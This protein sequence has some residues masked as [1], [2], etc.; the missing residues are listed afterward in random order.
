MKIDE[1]Y[2]QF[3]KIDANIKNTILLPLTDKN[4]GTCFAG[5]EQGEI[6]LL[7]AAVGLANCAREK[8]KKTTDIR[9]YA[10]LSEDHKILIRAIA[11]SASKHD[12]SILFRGTEVLKIVEEYANGGLKILHEKIH[13][14]GFDMSIEEEISKMLKEIE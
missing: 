2:P 1:N 4:T 8:S 14:N 12:Y 6:Y 13:S 11:L 7:G 9:L 3:I 10:K 5:Q